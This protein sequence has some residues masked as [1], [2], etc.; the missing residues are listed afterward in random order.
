MELIIQ[1]DQIEVAARLFWQKVSGKVF[2]FH[3]EM[4]AG[5]TTFITALCFAKGVR[6]AMGSPTFSLINEY[7]FVE[8][9]ESH[10]IF[11]LD[12]YRVKDETEAINAGI[13]DCLYS[14]NICF[15]EWP[16]KIP[17]LLPEDAVHISIVVIDETCRLLK[18]ADS[19][20]KF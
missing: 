10:T 5:K 11:H 19:A 9:G 8:D 2:A 20:V 12:L 18:I 4:G 13:E 17:G 3:G 16:E 15:V 6:S 14:G 1:L 7:V